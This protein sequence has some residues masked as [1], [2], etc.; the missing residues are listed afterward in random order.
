[1][2]ICRWAGCL[3]AFITFICNPQWLEIKRVLLLGQQ[4]QDR[5]DLVTRMFKIKLKELINNIHKKHILGPTIARIYVV[6]F[7]KRGLPHAH[8]LIFFTKDYKPHT[9]EDV[10]RMISAELPNSETNKLAHETVA[11]CMMHGPCGAPF[12]NAPCMEEGKC[13]KQN[14]RKFQS[15][16]V[17]DVNGY[18]IYQRRDTGHTILVHGIELDNRWVVPHNVY[19][20]MKYDAHINVEVCN[21]IRAVKYLFNDNATE[22][23][24]VETDEIKKYFD[25]R[26]VSASEASWRIF[27]FDMHE[28]F[29]IVE[30]LQYH[31]PNMQMV[32]FNDDDDLQ[33]VATWSAI[34]RTMLTEWFKTNQESEVA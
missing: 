9:V 27:K 7:Q 24:M 34:S 18:P 23:N 30:R 12:P 26:Y 31:L 10:D 4:P 11:R 33:E 16:T 20:S 8:N 19:L 1:M 22:K 13:K 6:E 17:T 2:A 29:P 21:N 5:Q 3:D 32:L 25:C 28:R 14:P 15:K